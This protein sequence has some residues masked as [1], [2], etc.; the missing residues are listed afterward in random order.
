MKLFRAIRNERGVVALNEGLLVAIMA[1]GLIGSIGDV[2]DSI[3]ATFDT[4]G[5]AMRGGGTSQGGEGCDPNHT[6]RSQAGNG[7][8]YGD[9]CEPPPAAD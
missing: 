2:K 6:A 8:S 7:S 9:G 3:A 1:V 4:A 5:L